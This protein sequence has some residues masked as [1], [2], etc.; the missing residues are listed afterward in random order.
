MRVAV[1][2]FRR[3]AHQGHHFIHTLVFFC[4]GHFREVEIQHLV[5]LCAYRV[6][7]VQAGHGILK[8][9]GDFL[10]TQG[11]HFRLRQGE[12]V[13]SIVVD[14]ALYDFAYLGRQQPQDG[15]S[16]CGF[17]C[18]GFAHQSSGFTTH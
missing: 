1:L 5:N 12:Q 6:G 10:A 3:N 11:K 8:D 16:C 2:S 13:F 4:P 14:A 18:A 15:Q 17:A 9:H 7:R